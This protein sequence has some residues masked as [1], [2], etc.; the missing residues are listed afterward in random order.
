MVQPPASSRP[1]RSS[2]FIVFP[3]FRFLAHPVLDVVVDDEVQLFVRKAVVV[4]PGSIDVVNNGLRKPR[5]ELLVADC[6]PRIQRL[7]GRTSPLPPVP[8][9]CGH[10]WTPTR[11]AGSRLGEKRKGRLVTGPDPL[12]DCLAGFEPATLRLA[13]VCSIR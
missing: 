12:H 3:L 5:I 11:S 4:A 2:K 10:L 1:S 7:S 13:T 6:A 8:R 9:G